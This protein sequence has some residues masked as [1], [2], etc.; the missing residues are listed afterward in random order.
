MTVWARCKTF[1]LFHKFNHWR[2][3]TNNHFR[4]FFW[5][6]I[7]RFEELIQIFREPK[8]WISQNDIETAFW[9]LFNLLSKWKVEIVK[10]EVL[11]DLETSVEL[12]Q[13][14][15]F[16]E[17]WG[18]L[19]HST[20]YRWSSNNCDSTILF[21]FWQGFYRKIGLIKAKCFESQFYKSLNFSYQPIL[22][23]FSIPILGQICARIKSTLK[24]YGKIE[25]LR[26]CG[27][28]LVTPLSLLRQKQTRNY[29]FMFVLIPYC[30][31]RC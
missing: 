19:F 4:I 29:Y 16:Q 12:E 30:E 9:K 17:I 15:F 13:L 20:K 23:V 7:D 28:F 5:N 18:D 21:I 8:R 26:L 3:G 2:S 24:S 1:R 22:G 31:V 11:V 27:H 10:R 25:I 14:R 6:E